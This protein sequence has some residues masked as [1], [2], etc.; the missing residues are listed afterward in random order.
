MIMTLEVKKPSAKDLFIYFF[1]LIVSVSI[2]FANINSQQV[3]YLQSTANSQSSLTFNIWGYHNVT[4]VA[5]N[6]NDEYTIMAF[7]QYYI[8]YPVCEFLYNGETSVYTCS[9]TIFY[10][11]SQDNLLFIRVMLVIVY[12][13]LFLSLLSLFTNSYTPNLLLLVILLLLM[14]S[15]GLIVNNILNS[16]FLIC[17]TVLFVYLLFSIEKLTGE[18][19]KV[20]SQSTNNVE[21]VT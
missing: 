20:H 7:N 18:E 6:I 15:I 8:E 10:I 12:I 19:I 17:N 3:S 14:I 11:G 21:L 13:L 2:N 1:I 16:V 4:I 5:S 9:K